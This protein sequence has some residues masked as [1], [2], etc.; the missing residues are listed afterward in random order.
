MVPRRAFWWASA[1][2]VIAVIVCI[3]FWRW[4][5]DGESNSATI[6]NLGLLAVVPLSFWLAMWR[7]S[8]A[9]SQAA[10]ARGSLLNEHYQRGA[11]ML[12]S[13]T[14]LEHT[15][16]VH[17]LRQIAQENPDAYRHQ[18]V[19]LLAAFVQHPPRDAS[20]DPDIASAGN[21]VK[22]AIEAIDSCRSY[23]SGPLIELDLQGANLRQIVLYG[24]SLEHAD[25]TGARLRGA[26]LEDVNLSGAELSKADL[27]DAQLG[28]PEPHMPCLLIETNLRDA[29]LGRADLADN[30][31]RGSDLSGASLSDASLVG[32]DL[33]GADLTAADLTDADLAFVKL[34]GA[35]LTEAKLTNTVLSG[36]RLF[37]DDP[38]VPDAAPVRGLK[39]AQLD[40]A[41]ADRE[42]P[43][44]L[45]DTVRDA[46]TGLPVTWNGT[47]S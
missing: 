27:R 5:S 47:S 3:C 25:L 19:R 7:N 33:R 28:G 8:I 10:T 36:A 16:G 37:A 18:V 38:E 34:S 14:Q 12:A 20:Y 17:A 26:R 41:R 44:R 35:N 6:R 1:V 31:L 9:Q 40:A 32:A 30:D 21:D 23:A 11:E 2:L 46:E 39:Q 24:I 29:N 43:P 13:E 4:L 22:S 45:D 15:G 42:W